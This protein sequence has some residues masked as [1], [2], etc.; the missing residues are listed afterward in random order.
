[1]VVSGYAITVVNIKFPNGLDA[2]KQERQWQTDTMDSIEDL[3]I[4]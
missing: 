3:E 2:V 1:M 4:V